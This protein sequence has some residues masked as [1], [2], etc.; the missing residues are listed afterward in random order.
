MGCGCGGSDPAAAAAAAASGVTAYTIQ[1]PNGTK[2]GKYPTAAHA[3]VA[4][5]TQFAGRGQVV[6]R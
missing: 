6:P 4:L 2:A 1:L 3:E 5:R